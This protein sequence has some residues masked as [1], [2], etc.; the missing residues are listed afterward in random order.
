[1]IPGYRLE[2]L[3]SS[4]GTSE[5]YHAAQ[6]ASG[7][8]CLI[9]IVDADEKN[10][11]KFL[12]EAEKAP[13]LF[14]PGLATIYEIGTVAS[15]DVFVVS[16]SPEGNSLSELFHDVGA[17]ELLTALRIAWQTAEALHVLHQNGLVHRAVNPANIVI[18][19][20]ASQGV[21]VK[22][23]ALDFAGIDGRHVDSDK[24]LTGASLYSLRYFAPEQCTLGSATPQSDVYSLGVVFYEM[25][26]GVPPFEA[27]SAA[28]LIHGTA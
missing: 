3:A 12:L 8:P 23:Q 20:D 6:T 27:S 18:S 2:Y 13:A 5:L 9:R 1:M 11:D 24:F 4:A 25:L 7:R 16:E 15:G 21:Q 14:H 26:A 10:L 17:P 19:E 28:A 22:L